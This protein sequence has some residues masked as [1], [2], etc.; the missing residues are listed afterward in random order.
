MGLTALEILNRL[1]RRWWRGE[2]R[3]TSLSPQITRLK[4]DGKVVSE[5]GMWGLTKDSA[6][7]EESNGAL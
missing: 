3:R 5:R 6:P 7:S 2:L 1:N 4:K